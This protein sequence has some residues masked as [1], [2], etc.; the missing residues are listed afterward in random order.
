MK[1]AS[2]AATSSTTSSVRA[3]TIPATGVAAP[4]RMLVAVRAIAPVAGSPPNSGE[5]MLA[6]PC[7]TSSTFGLCR[8]PLIRS[9]TTADISDSIAPSIATVSAGRISVG[10][11]RRVE[12]RQVRHR[13]AGR[14]AAEAAADGLDRQAR[15][16][17]PAAVPPTSATI[18]PGTAGT[19]R[20]STR[21]TASAGDAEHGRGRVNRVQVPRRATP[22]APRTPPAPGRCAARGSP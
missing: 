7:A 18:A 8:S 16:P 2:G 12:R 3:C 15:Q 1:L 4:E 10:I 11:E 13:Q 9:A 19:V 5:A 6:M 14:D 20:R 21:M 22:S 17:S